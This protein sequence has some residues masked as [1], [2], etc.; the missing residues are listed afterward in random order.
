MQENITIELKNDLVRMY[1]LSAEL[2]NELQANDS[3]TDLMKLLD[4]VR[5]V[6]KDIEGTLQKDIFNCD[7]L[8]SKII[9]ESSAD[10]ELH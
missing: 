3:R 8:V 1:R 9:M 10:Q 7:Y 4:R 5:F 6:L 2:L